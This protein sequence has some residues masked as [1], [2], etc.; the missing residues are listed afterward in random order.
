MFALQACLVEE[1]DSAWAGYIMCW[2]GVVGMLSIVG[3]RLLS[4]GAVEATIHRTLSH[5]S[6]AK[7]RK[8]TAATTDPAP[9]EPVDTMPAD[10]PPA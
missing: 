7:S 5:S 1:Q 3:W 8:S 2:L 4:V 6:S 10:E 9:N